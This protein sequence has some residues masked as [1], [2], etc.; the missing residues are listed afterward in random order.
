MQ[1]HD[2]FSRQLAL[3]ALGPN[4]LQPGDPGEPLWLCSRCGACHDEDITAWVCCRGRT[5]KRY[6]CSN[7]RAPHHEPFEAQHCCECVGVPQPMQCP[8]CMRE[9]E[10]FQDAADCC[11]HT[12]PGLTALA[13]ERVARSVAQGMP[14][15]HAIESHATL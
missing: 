7:C 5:A 10:S 3:N 13:R 8:I 12:H 9:G 14:W 6:L 4:Q 1:T 15:A 2:F 11:L